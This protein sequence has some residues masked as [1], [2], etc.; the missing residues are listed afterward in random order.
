VISSCKARASDA[1]PGP[2]LEGK[3]CHSLGMMIVPCLMWMMIFRGSESETQ[4]IKWSGPWFP[5]DSPLPILGLEISTAGAGSQ[6]DDR[7]CTS[8][9]QSASWT[10]HAP[11]LA[12]QA[13]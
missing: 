5:E 9:P 12:M 11:G 1:V 7:I 6:S 2:G 8:M 10:C 13:V 3:N 4:V